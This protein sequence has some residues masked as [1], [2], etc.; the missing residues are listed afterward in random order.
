MADHEWQNDPMFES[1][2][3]FF[4]HHYGQPG[5][6]NLVMNAA[7]STESALLALENG[8]RDQ[9]ERLWRSVDGVALLSAW[10]ASNERCKELGP[11]WLLQRTDA[12]ATRDKLANSSI[13][14][15]VYS[16]DVYRCR[17]CG[18]PVFTRNKGSRML[19]LIEAFPV[20][21]ENRKFE[22]KRLASF[23]CKSRF[24]TFHQ[25]S[26]RS[27]TA[28]TP[29]LIEPLITPVKARP[30]CR[31]SVKASLSSP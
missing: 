21:R 29:N 16:R 15:R 7:M 28:P 22:P 11:K 6:L 1:P 27:P 17:Y 30:S 10:D 26:N 24:L 4:L 14:K 20:F 3:H 5:D 19:K 25:S 18:S 12:V 8:D 23:G 9:A 31:K 2:T 13:A